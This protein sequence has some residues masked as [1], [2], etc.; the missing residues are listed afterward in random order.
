MSHAQISEKV[1]LG[2]QERGQENAHH[3][4]GQFNK[5]SGDQ[6]SQGMMS[7]PPDTRGELP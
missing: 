7:I 5:T 4:Y 2:P 1:V 3:S 6:N